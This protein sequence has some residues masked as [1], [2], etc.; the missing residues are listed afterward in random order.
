[1][2]T[3]LWVVCFKNFEDP[4]HWYDTKFTA[5]WWTFEQEHSV[6]AEVLFQGLC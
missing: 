5:C 4:H 6:I 1:M 3:G 2:F